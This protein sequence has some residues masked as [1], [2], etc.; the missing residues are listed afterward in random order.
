MRVIQILTLVL[1][2]SV[3]V[4]AQTTT[5]GPLEISGQLIPGAVY[6]PY[7]PQ[8]GVQA[9]RATR[10]RLEITNPTKDVIKVPQLL[11]SFYDGN[12]QALFTD[13]QQAVVK[14]GKT[15]TLYLYYNNAARIQVTSVLVTA[16][17]ESSGK[18]FQ[19]QV[20]VTPTGQER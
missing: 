10:V 20:A 6:D 14:P 9:D 11:G 2:L 1:L 19:N 5:G 3:G 8:S 12:G 15:E 16:S 17:Y 7:C 18:S 13:R 4:L